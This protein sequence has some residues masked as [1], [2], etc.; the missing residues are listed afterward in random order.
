MSYTNWYSGIPILLQLE[1]S[2]LSTTSECSPV[3]PLA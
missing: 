3:D 2:I 1:I